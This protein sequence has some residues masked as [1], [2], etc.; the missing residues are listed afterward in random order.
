MVQEQDHSVFQSRLDA[1]FGEMKWLHGERYQGDEQAFSRY[2]QALSDAW[3]HRSSV[4]K[5]R[6]ESGDGTHETVGD[7]PYR[8]SRDYSELITDF[9]TLCNQGVDIVRFDAAYLRRL[10]DS[11]GIHEACVELRMMRMAAEIVCPFVML[12]GEPDLEPGDAAVYFGEPWKPAC[13]LLRNM[14]LPAYLWHTVA[15]RDVRLL[16]HLLGSMQ[17]LPRSFHFLNDLQC[18][19]AVEWKLDFGFLKQYSIEEGAH[20]SYLN[21]YFMGVWPGS[22]ARGMLAPDGRGIRGSTAALCGIQG[23]KQE[24]DADRLERAV[25]LYVMLH[26]FLYTL[27]GI[28]SLHE[29]EE[30]AFLMD[31]GRT[32]HDRIRQFVQ[33]RAAQRVFDNRA[34]VW[35]LE[36]WNDHVLGIGRYYEGQKLLALFNFNDNMEIAWID[37]PEPYSDLLTDAFREAKAVE[38]PAFGF[39]WLVTQF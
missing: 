21:D 39:A 13:H 5:A 32:V 23:A 18:G 11:L 10:T 35:L 34:D 20:C 33:L 37:E 28:P 2:V 25:R 16:K 19:D 29:E 30:A 6:D 9:L 38:L 27:S 1:R 8:E 36:T 7:M 24:D 31:R 3:D 26:A 15:V 17:T 12:L 22:D 4:L 14:R